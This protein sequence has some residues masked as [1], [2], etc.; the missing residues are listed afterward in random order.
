MRAPAV[1]ISSQ[2]RKSVPYAAKRARRQWLVASLVLVVALIGC[3]LAFKPHKPSSPSTGIAY[4]DRLIALPEEQIDIGLVALQLSKDFSPDLNVEAYSQ[5][6]DD[7]V[8]KV[9]QKT[10][11][12]TSPDIRIR[13][14]NT[15]IYQ[16]EGYHYDFEAVAKQDRNG[17]RLNYVL[18]TKKGT[19]L[20]LT[21]LYLAVAQRL[22]YPI[23]P[24]MMPKHAFLRYIGGDFGMY[25]IEASNGGGYSPDEFYDDYMKPS[26]GAVEHGVYLRTCTYREFIGCLLDSNAMAYEIL[27]DNGMKAAHL[28]AAVAMAPD[29][30]PACARLAITLRDVS[31]TLKGKKAEHFY[32]QGV[33]LLQHV[34]DLGDIGIVEFPENLEQTVR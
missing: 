25:N 3:L 17:G 7:L 26:K 34:M 6:L 10:N 18:D 19:C 23:Y 20:G 27:G 11:G 16:D 24:V 31:Y 14:L 32:Q 5:R 29:Y 15:V 12:A 33:E 28:E 22:G 30:T 4:L 21:V 8:A 9:R 13:A 2:P 1:F